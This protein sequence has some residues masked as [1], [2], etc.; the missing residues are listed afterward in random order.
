[1]LA[2]VAAGAGA[3]TV[4][5]SPKGD[6][7]HYNTWAWIPG[8]EQG[9]QG[10]LSD[11]TMRARVEQAIAVRLKTAGLLPVTGDAKPDLLVRYRGDIGDGKEVTT[12][13]GGYMVWDD[14][15]NA[16]I[17][18]TVQDATLMVDL[19]DASKN[20]LVWRLYVNQTIQ[21]PNDE[22]DKFAKALDKGFEQYPPTAAEV[23]RKAREL[24]KASG[25]K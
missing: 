3:I 13:Q 6:F 5:F 2:F 16:T 1:M 12:S 18:F 19:V 23:A 14:P 10:V 8:R 7:K 20:M 17:H 22:S 4:D 11:A 9:H 21:G 15:I 24:E 25:A